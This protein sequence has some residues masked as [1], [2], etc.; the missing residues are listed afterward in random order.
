MKRTRMRRQGVR[1]R[2][3]QAAI[4]KLKPA[5]LARAGGRCENPW[6]RRRRPL[7]PHHIQ[8]RSAGGPD[9]LE[10]LVALCRPC[11]EATDKPF[12]DRLN[13][14]RVMGRIV[15]FTAIDSIMTSPGR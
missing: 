12:Y 6:C 2:R 10:N 9:T 13:I 14:R 3:R 1:G 15:F 5:L 8:K 4:A 7:D 11:H